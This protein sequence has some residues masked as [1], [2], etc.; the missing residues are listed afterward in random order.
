M[1]VYVEVRADKW[2]KM[3][4]AQT[5]AHIHRRFS[6][7]LD[8]LGKS[9]DIEVESI[10]EEGEN[11]LSVRYEDCDITTVSR[12]NLK[13]M[14]SSATKILT[15]DRGIMNVPWD[16]TI[17]QKLV[18]DGSDQA[19]CNVHVPGVAIICACP[20]YKSA[21]MCLCSLVV[22]VHELCLPQFFALIRKRKKLPNPY[23]LDGQNLR[24][25]QVKKKHHERERQ[26]RPS[27]L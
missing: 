4:N 20:K 7:P 14:W 15:H 19:T 25:Q 5:E 3:T 9:H 1:N 18:F 10:C 26:L 22:A 6:N 17:S 11:K 12:S 24:G 16:D 8:S 21:I 23:L 13:Q 2:L 27:S